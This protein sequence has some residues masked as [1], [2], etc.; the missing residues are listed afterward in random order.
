MVIK[1]Q[2]VAICNT[3]ISN[4]TET[5]GRIDS[6]ICKRSILMFQISV[7][8]GLLETTIPT[9][10]AGRIVKRNIIAMQ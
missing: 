8:T 3:K 5:Y 2:M 6:I 9:P 10:L 4:I 1:R 7:G